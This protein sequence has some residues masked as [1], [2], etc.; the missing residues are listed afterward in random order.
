MTYRI[1]KVKPAIVRGTQR[2]IVKELGDVGIGKARDGY[3]E[4]AK[5][6]AS[7]GKQYRLVNA[8]DVI[9]EKGGR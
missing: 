4:W 6:H 1:E 2:Q 7:D 3:R 8:Q 9:V 5:A